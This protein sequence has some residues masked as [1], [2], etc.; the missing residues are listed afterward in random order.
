MDLVEHEVGHTLGWVHSATEPGPPE[1]YL[2]ALDVMSNSAAPRVAD[3]TSRDAPDTLALDRLISGWLPT[4]AV[5]AASQGTTVV[6][7]PSTGAD[8]VRLLVLPVDDASFLTV[9]LLSA[10][11]HDA[12]LPGG[13]VAV[14]RVEVRGGAVERVTPLVGVAPFTTLLRPGDELTTDGWAVSVSPG[15]AVHAQRSDGTAHTVTS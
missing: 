9:E 11:G 8:G 6:L 5:R 14:H 13:G 2:S 3:P 4:S 10:D 15:G 7:R 1:H 12:H